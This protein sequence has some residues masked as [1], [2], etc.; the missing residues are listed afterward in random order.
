MV[1]LI[2][3]PVSL[4]RPN[5]EVLL[6]SSRVSARFGNTLRISGVHWARDTH[7]EKDH[8]RDTAQNVT[9]RLEQM[10]KLGHTTCKTRNATN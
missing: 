9:A 5:P 4:R 1:C 8:Q 7:P 2:N 10:G 6:V 3:W